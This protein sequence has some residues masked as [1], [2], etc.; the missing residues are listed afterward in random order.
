NGDYVHGGPEELLKR[1]D[2]TADV[3]LMMPDVPAWIAE[4]LAVLGGPQPDVR[5]GEHCRAPSD[6]PFQTRCWPASM[7]GVLRVHGLRYDKRFK[8]LH[9]GIAT[10][11]ALPK[12]FKLNDVQE[13]QRLALERH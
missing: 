12:D 5:I 13:R 9:D 10:I 1:V 6:C 3:E 4:Q 11:P 7:D 8:L 2:V